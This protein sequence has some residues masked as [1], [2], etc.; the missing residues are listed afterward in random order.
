MPL[1]GLDWR[2]FNHKQ[3]EFY[4]HINFLKAGLVFADLLTTVSP[5]YALEIQTPYFGCGLEGVLKERHERL[6]GIVNGVD[7]GVWD[8]A[9][10]RNLAANYDVDTVGRGKPACKAA[11]QR[12]YGLDPE[13][14]TPLLGMVSRLVEPKG[15]DLIGNAAGPLL[16]GGA[17]LVILGEG[18]PYYHRLLLALRDRYPQRFGLTLA[19]DEPLAH[20]IQ[21]GADIYLMPSLY[22]PSGLNQLYSLRYGT[23]PVVRRTGGLADTIVDCTPETLQAGTANGFGFLPQT[24]A[25][26]LEAVRRALDLYARQPDKW[27]ELLQTGMRQDWSWDRSA[28]EYEKLYLTLC[29]HGPRWP[30]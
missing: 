22:E 14:R 29:K 28:A 9:T 1:L 21:A 27:M 13:P 4:G 25:A 5:T 6:F 15:L 18:D 30:T 3:L 8:P 23:V 20:Q 16:Q 24:A 2:L 17:Q 7:Y 11:L 26:L 10:D 12:R 19:F